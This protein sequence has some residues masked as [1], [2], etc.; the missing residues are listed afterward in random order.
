MMPV[1]KGGSKGNRL[2]NRM[3][4]SPQT[5][6]AKNISSVRG[7]QGLNSLDFFRLATRIRFFHPPRWHQKSSP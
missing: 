3:L 5:E 2:S 6:C 7:C 1:E 4:N